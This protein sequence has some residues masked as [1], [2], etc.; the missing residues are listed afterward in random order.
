[1]FIHIIDAGGDRR[2]SDLLHLEHSIGQ[3]LGGSVRRRRYLRRSLRRRTRSFGRTFVDLVSLKRTARGTVQFFS[4]FRRKKNEAVRAH[5]RVGTTAAAN[6]VRSSQKKTTTDGN[7]I[8]GPCLE[9]KDVT[10]TPPQFLI[11]YRS[12]FDFARCS[13]EY[14]SCGWFICMV[15]CV[16][17][18]VFDV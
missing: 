9:G 1:M 18:C 10:T 4:Y 14:N 11:E 13:C 17:F 5:G 3:T 8:R 2:R 15:L 6:E 7:R 16:P 12:A